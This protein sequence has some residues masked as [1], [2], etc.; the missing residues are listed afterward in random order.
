MIR[1]VFLVDSTARNRAA[2]SHSLQGTKFHIEPFESATELTSHWPQ[3]GLLLVHDEGSTVSDLLTH[4][5]TFGEWLPV[6]CFAETPS[7]QRVVN[8]VMQGAAN[9]IAWPFT[10]EQLEEAIDAAQTQASGIA[11][12]KL[13][14]A[15]ARS[16]V[17][18]LTRRER[19]VLVGVADGLSNRLIGNK[20]SISP[21]TVEIHRANMLTKM[22]VSHSSEAIR[23]AV[24]AALVY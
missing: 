1:S 11:S 10:G 21:R 23:F 6:I 22:G 13:R 17:N 18:Q 24:E 8:A 9:Y 20:L 16:K 5:S 3:Y 14:E 7:T 12:L 19:E 2:I 4:M 15:M